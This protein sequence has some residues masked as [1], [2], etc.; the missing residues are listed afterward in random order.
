MQRYELYHPDDLVHGPLVK[1]KGGRY[2]LYTDV[3][4]MEAE[5]KA[6]MEE[7]EKQIAALTVEL[8]EYRTMWA[9]EVATLKAA[10]A[11][12]DKEIA[13]LKKEMQRREDYL[14]SL[15]I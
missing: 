5:H 4:A 9:Y 8:A 13:A 11:E 12:R 6:E 14:D 7:K 15:L 3:E 2:V 10:L 1:N